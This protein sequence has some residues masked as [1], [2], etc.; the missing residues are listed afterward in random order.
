MLPSSVDAGP[1]DPQLRGGLSDHPEELPLA[2]VHGAVKNR[3]VARL[4]VN[5]VVDI[6]LLATMPFDS[7]IS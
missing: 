1:D 2:G 4:A 3:S 7:S 6:T 5:L